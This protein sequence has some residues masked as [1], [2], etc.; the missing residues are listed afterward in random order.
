MANYKLPRK[1]R[2]INKIQSKPQRHDTWKWSQFCKDMLMCI[3]FDIHIK[4]WGNDGIVEKIWK[5]K[6]VMEWFYG[7]ASVCFPSVFLNRQLT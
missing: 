3:Y 5:Q 1:S 7:F 2:E 4:E 6:E